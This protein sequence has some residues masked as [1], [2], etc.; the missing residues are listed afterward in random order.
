MHLEKDFFQQ[1]RVQ[2]RL[3]SVFALLEKKVQSVSMQKPR[4]LDF[5]FERFYARKVLFNNNYTC[6]FHFFKHLV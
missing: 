4:V 2:S 3:L 1:D 6:Y 5:E